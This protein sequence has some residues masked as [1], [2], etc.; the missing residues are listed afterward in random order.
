MISKLDFQGSFMD[1][2][3]LIAIHMKGFLYLS[4]RL[5]PVNTVI[6]SLLF[7]YDILQ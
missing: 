6:A 1:F 5:A 3:H 4:V 7:M 2:I